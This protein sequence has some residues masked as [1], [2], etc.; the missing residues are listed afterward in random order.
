MKTDA[1]SIGLGERFGYI[2]RMPKPSPLLKYIQRETTRHGKTVYYFRAG[3]GH[4]RRLPDDYG[5]KEFMDAYGALFE[6]ESYNPRWRPPTA[7]ERQRK[8]ARTAIIRAI[9][10]AKHRSGKSGLPFSIAKEWAIDRMEKNDYRCEETGIPFLMKC[11]A[12]SFMRP[13]VPSLDRRDPCKGYTEENVRI[14]VFAFNAMVSDWG[15]AVMHRIANGYRH[16]QTVKRTS[17]P[18]RRIQ[19]TP[20]HE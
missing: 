17:I 11:D 16:A 7:S 10:R 3:M 20:H 2:A 1:N 13:Y 19:A 18:L 5:S 4:R 14:V 8:D 9:A 15:D 12:Q 6:D